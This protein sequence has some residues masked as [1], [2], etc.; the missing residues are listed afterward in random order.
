M[1]SDEEKTIL[2]LGTASNF[3]QYPKGIRRIERIDQ[4]SNLEFNT[5]AERW[6]VSPFPAC[7][8]LVFLSHL[9]KDSVL[10][11]AKARR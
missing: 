3:S 1:S 11:R 7:A 2:G 10:L 5:S 8:V 4:V 6:P 9:S